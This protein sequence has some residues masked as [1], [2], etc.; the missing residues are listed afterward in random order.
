MPRYERK[1]VLQETMFKID[2]RKRP[3][4]MPRDLDVVAKRPYFGLLRCCLGNTRSC[5]PLLATPPTLSC[6]TLILRTSLGNTLILRTLG[7]V[8]CEQ[9]NSMSCAHVL[10]TYLARISCRITRNTRKF[11]MSC[12]HV[13]RA[14]LV[15]SC[16]HVLRACLARMSCSSTRK[17]CTSC[18]H[19]LRTCLVY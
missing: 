11:C 7:A 2:T 15:V 3:I 12:A 17:F 13:L 10:R 8:S 19:V 18:V 6:D 5:G 1:I 16:V 9:A 4:Y 14:C